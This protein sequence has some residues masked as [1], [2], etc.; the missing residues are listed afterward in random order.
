MQLKVHM[1]IYVIKMTTK[2]PEN[3]RT[4]YDVSVRIYDTYYNKL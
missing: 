3:Y 2:T 1:I 4:F